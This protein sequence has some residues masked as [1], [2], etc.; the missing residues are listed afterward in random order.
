MIS[1]T[2]YEFKCQAFPFVNEVDREELSKYLTEAANDGW[3]LVDK[4]VECAVKDGEFH[5]LVVFTHKRKKKEAKADT[6]GGSSIY[7]S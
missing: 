5:I 3:L 1:P 7:T 6:A 2:K 4:K